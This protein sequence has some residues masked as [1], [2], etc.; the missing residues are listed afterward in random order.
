MA[1]ILK[2]IQNGDHIL[3]E[4]SHICLIN[5]RKGGFLEQEKF[6]D[7]FDM[8]EDIDRTKKN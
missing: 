8:P 3:T 4:K 1:T 2:I 6:L 7:D 5:I